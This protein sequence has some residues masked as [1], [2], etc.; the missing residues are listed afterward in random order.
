MGR[1]R[2]AI[3]H[4]RFALAAILCIAQGVGVALAAQSPAFGIGHP[5]DAARLKQ[6][7]IDVTPDGKG[8]PGGSGTDR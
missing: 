6:I 3:A 2:M 8:L 1:S 5:P 4:K 7:D